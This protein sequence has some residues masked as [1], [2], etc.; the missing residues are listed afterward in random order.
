[1][2][3]SYKQAQIKIEG[4][5]LYEIRNEFKNCPETLQPESSEQH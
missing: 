5:D 2:G 3:V 4:P 1:M